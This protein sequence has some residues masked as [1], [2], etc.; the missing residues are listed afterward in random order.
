MQ[1]YLFLAQKKLTNPCWLYFAPSLGNFNF[2]TE[3][4]F[5]SNWAV[6]ICQ[7]E[8]LSFSLTF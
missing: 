4:F 3:K 6:K 1:E 2:S 7:L 8:K 5:F